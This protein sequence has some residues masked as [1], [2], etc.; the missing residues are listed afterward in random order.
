MMSTEINQLIRTLYDAM[1]S[2]YIQTNDDK[3]IDLLA[4]AANTIKHLI[5]NNKQLHN[6]LIIQTALAQNSQNF[7]EENKQLIKKINMLF[8][9]FKEVVLESDEVCKY[10]KY[11]QPCEGK[12]CKQYIEGVGGW[13]HNEYHHDWKW[14]CQNFNYGECPKLENTYCNGCDFKTNWKWRGD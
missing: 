10:C 8:Q 2:E 9:D 7:I 12:S 13:L 5:E 1:D 14:N 3:I 4:Q 6:D 11:Q